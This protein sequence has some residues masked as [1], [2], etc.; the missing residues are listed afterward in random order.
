MVVIGNR[1]DWN[2]EKGAGVTKC[3]NVGILLDNRRGIDLRTNNNVGNSDGK[4]GNG[5]SMSSRRMGTCPQLIGCA[6]FE[7]WSLISDCKLKEQKGYSTGRLSVQEVSTENQKMAVLYARH[8]HTK[9]LL[10]VFR[11]T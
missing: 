1:E 4:M 11:G 6:L 3:Q 5:T 7:I 10:A 9:T 8:W 2:S